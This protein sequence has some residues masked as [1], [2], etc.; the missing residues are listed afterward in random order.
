MKQ[1]T[2]NYELELYRQII[3]KMNRLGFNFED[4]SHIK[5]CSDLVDAINRVIVE[6]KSRIDSAEDGASQVLYTLAKEELDNFLYVGLVDSELFHLFRTPK[7]GDILTFAKRLDSELE[8]SP[9]TFSGK[10][11][12]DA[13]VLLGEPLWQGF[14]RNTNDDITKILDDDSTIPFLADNLFGLHRIFGLYKIKTT[15]IITAFTDFDVHNVEVTDD[16]L[17]IT[18]DRGNPVVI[19]YKGPM[20]LTHQWVFKRLRI[21]DVKAVEELRQTSD[22]LQSN[23]RRSNRGAYYT[24]KFL[25]IEMGNKVL[26]CIK[27]DFIIEPYAGAGSLLI[28]FV[29]KGYIRGWVND[30]DDDASG[31]LGADYGAVGYTVTC[32]DLIDFPVS[33]ALEIIGDVKN[34]LFITNPPFSSTLARHGTKVEKIFYGDLG[35]KYGRGNQ[36]YPTIGKVIEILKKLKRGYLA[37]FSPFGVFCER[38]GHMKLLMGLLNHF[39]FIDGYIWSGRHFNDVSGN[40][41]ISFTIWKYGGSTDLESIQFKCEDVGKVGFKRYSLLKD[42]WRYRDG[43]KYVISSLGKNEVGV[44]NTSYFSTPYPKFFTTNITEG[45]SALLRIENVKRNLGIENIPSELI[46]GLWSTVVGLRSIVG[47]PLHFDN[48]YVHVPD[49]TK[50]ESVEILAYTLLYVFVGNDYTNGKIG[51]IGPRKIFKF[52]DSDR[53]NSGAKYLFETYGNL[54]VGEQT[55]SQVLEEIKQG[56]KRKNWRIDIRK[57]VSSRLDAIGYWD[58]IP[59]PLKQETKTYSLLKEPKK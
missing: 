58:Y 39:T 17:I 34:P 48:A 37:F 29:N 13:M 14:W 26:E 8:V 21:P 47:N 11:I 44:V 5:G 56:N 40:K 51:F 53:L 10:H 24:E 35:N 36:I 28:P 54:S 16:R 23:K 2:F 33:K 25:S 22:R 45:A 52:G 57:E 12:A 9:S 30:Y 50:D 20:K 18:R 27:P 46:Y 4:T 7:Y 59:L 32:K 43:A 41:P 15:D 38:K 1:G 6:V 49:L 31:M 19:K 3:K 55:I 42:G